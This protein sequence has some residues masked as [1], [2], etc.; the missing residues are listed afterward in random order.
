MIDAV[1]ELYSRREDYTVREKDKESVRT[2]FA[3]HMYCLPDDCLIKN[4]PVDLPWK[5]G[6]PASA[7]QT[8]LELIINPITPATV[9]A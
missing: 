4:Y 5:N 6:V 8:T 3:A 1:P 7:L 2:D 9:T